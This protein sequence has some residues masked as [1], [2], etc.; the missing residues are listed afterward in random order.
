M[1]NWKTAVW[2]LALGVPLTVLADKPSMKAGQWEYNVKMEMPGMPFAMP[3]MKSQRCLTQAEIDRGDQFAKDEKNECQIKNL[4]Q[5]AGSASYDVT[6][7]DGSTGHYDF[8]YGNDAMQG[9]G[10]MD[11]QGQKMT[12]HFSSKRLG[13]CT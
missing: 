2:V 10:V 9:K 7:K 6:C 13:E 4:K 12:T 11:T 3:P 5:G 1:K 8:T